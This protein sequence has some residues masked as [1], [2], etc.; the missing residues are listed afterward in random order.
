VT[1]P[2]SEPTHVPASRL[3]RLAGEAG[4]AFGDL[5]TLLPLGLGA[6]AIGGL[7]LSSVLFGFGVALVA[8]GLFYGLPLAVQPMKVIAATIIAG[9]L[10]PGEVAAAGLMSG[11][12]LLVLA[13]T[14]AIGRLAWL[15][16]KS[17]TAGLQVGLG[18]TMAVLGL[19]LVLASPWLGLAAV[20]LLAVL[21]PL[22]RGIAAPSVLVIVSGLGWLAGLTVAPGGLAVGVTLPVFALP[23]TEEA[24]RG[25]WLGVVPQLP[26]TLTNAVILTAALARDLYPGA[27][28]A[29][30]RNLALTT[31]LGNL[32]L[33]PLGALPMCHGAGGLQAQ[34]RFGA[35]TGMAPA[36]LGALL[37]TLAVGLGNEAAA[38]LALIPSAAIGAL[39][40]AAGVDLAL[41][42]RLFDARPA[43]WPAIAAAAAATLV[44]NPA[45]GLAA[46][47]TIELVRSHARGTLDAIRRGAGR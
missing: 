47:W 31:G 21:L 5:G 32:V 29:S 8:S 43:C 4:G 16:P 11:A 34:H 18:L 13:A 25:F 12:L 19:D 22:G 14:G 23:T 10:G 27:R 42:K 3:G 39:L 28:R 2:R 33:A 17:V 7:A 26:L 45:L 30:E 46:G 37:L 24:W 15:I 36:I 35:R 44:L 41:S 6:V 9:E 1:T 20:G 38:L 40:L